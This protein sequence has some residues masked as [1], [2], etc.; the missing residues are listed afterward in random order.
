[1]KVFRVLGSIATRYTGELVLKLRVNPWPLLVH[2]SLGSPRQLN[3]G[4]Y[5]NSNSNQQQQQ[6]KKLCVQNA[7]NCA[8]V[9]RLNAVI[10]SAIA[11]MAAA[12]HHTVS[13]F[14]SFYCEKPDGE[15]IKAKT[16]IFR[17]SSDD[18]HYDEY[19]VIRL[20]VYN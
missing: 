20:A 18:G 4:N 2:R 17:Y 10:Y 1:M 16:T 11:S 3:K 8:S 14:V 5:G 7:H 6:Q 19:A 9:R 13:I 12:V 15:G